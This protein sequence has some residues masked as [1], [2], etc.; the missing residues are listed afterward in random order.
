MNSRATSAAVPNRGRLLARRI[1]GRELPGRRR[2]TLEV[3]F[4]QRAVLLDGGRY[5]AT[6][7]AGRHALE[8]WWRGE[9]ASAVLVD[10]SAI[11]LR[12]ERE[13]LVSA[14]GLRLRV[15]LELGLRVTTPEVFVAQRVREQSPYTLVHLQTELGGELLWLIDEL[16]TARGVGQ[17]T[18]TLGK[19][20]LGLDLLNR[21]QPLCERSGLLLERLV[22][23]RVEAPDAAATARFQ[24]Q[25]RLRRAEYELQMQEMAGGRARLA[26]RLRRERMEF[27]H[28][29]TAR[30][31][32]AEQRLEERRKWFE[33]QRVEQQVAAEAQLKKIRELASIHEDQRD[34]QHAR[35]IAEQ[36]AGLTVRSRPEPV[37]GVPDPGPVL[38]GEGGRP[39]GPLADWRRC[40]EH[41]IKY[42]RVEGACP[43]CEEPVVEESR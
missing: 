17:L 21:M 12:L 23:L 8:G 39:A 22:G 41:G 16:V 43:L 38:V 7:P 3:P 18:H 9:A 5:V 14:D 28:E 37:R 35:R 36:K 24:E 10:D 15:T 34:R 19:E 30:R 26:E 4:G 11:P 25:A 20:S 27:E 32:V 42:N 6:L 33:Q 13:N 31:Q 1:L 2:R 40:P 29:I